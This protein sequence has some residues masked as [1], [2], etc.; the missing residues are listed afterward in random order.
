[1]PGHSFVVVEFPAADTPLA[2]FTA[3]NPGTTL[4]AILE[5][6][7]QEDGD[8]VHHTTVL[9]KGADPRLLDA[10][11]DQLAKVYDHIEPIERDD[12]RRIWLGRVRVHEKAYTHN[13][14]AKAMVQ[15][16]HRYGAQWAHVEGG[17]AHLRARISD[18]AHGDLLADQMRRHFA[19]LGIEA[20][21][22]VRDIS[23]KDYGV[24]EDLVQRSIGLAP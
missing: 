15:F 9:L 22:E 12:R 3:R 6:M 18:P 20:Q 2:S 14:G 19:K 24:W 13:P 16:Q 10:F 17:I 8:A 21:V 5:P 7:Q 1:V 4:D 11:L 23:A